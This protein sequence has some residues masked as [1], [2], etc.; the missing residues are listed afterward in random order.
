[1]RHGGAEGL[2]PL[3]R[4]LDSPDVPEAWKLHTFRDK[5]FRY[6]WNVGDTKWAGDDP[7]R[8]RYPY[9]VGDA[10]VRAAFEKKYGGQKDVPIFGD[11]RIVPAFHSSGPVILQTDSPNKEQA[12]QARQ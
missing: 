7:R 3:S 2:T 6:L 5:G 4:R 10:D 1:L 9:H 8:V 11:P 12:E